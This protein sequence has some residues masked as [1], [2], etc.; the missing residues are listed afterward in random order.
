MEVQEKVY[1][2]AEQ[3]HLEDYLEEI[4]IRKIEIDLE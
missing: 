2:E 3:D 4:A 1:D